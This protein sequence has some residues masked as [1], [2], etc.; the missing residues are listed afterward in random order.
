MKVPIKEG[1]FVMPQSNEEQAYLIGGKCRSCGSIFFP[2][3]DICSNCMR[4]DLESFPLSKRGKLYSYTIVRQQPPEY[5]GTVPYAMGV[6]E[7]P[8]GVR[9]LTPLDTPDF[10]M[11]T[12][13][14]DLE[15]NIYKLYDEDEE[16]GNE[17]MA[18]KF[19]AVKEASK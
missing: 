14:L 1:L 8:E 9:V 15:L 7:L 5:K 12:V 6:V 4:E 10:D 19:R 17:V 3:Q 11:L 2:M 16:E 13:G 18:Y